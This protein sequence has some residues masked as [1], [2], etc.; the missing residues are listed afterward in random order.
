MGDSTVFNFNRFRSLI[1]LFQVILN[2]IFS[3]E[4]ADKKQ[5]DFDELSFINKKDARRGN[6]IKK[7]SVRNN[8]EKLY[9]RRH[10]IINTFSDGTCPKSSFLERYEWSDDDFNNTS[11]AEKVNE[12]LA[13]TQK[14]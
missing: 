10:V 7:E 1:E 11:V 8:V 12:P 5:D 6:T 3:L 9:N 13:K 2:E 4:A 14:L